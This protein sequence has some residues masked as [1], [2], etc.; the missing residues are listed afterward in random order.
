[1]PTL[2]YSDN[3][4][5]ET[6]FAVQDSGQKNRV[7]L[8]AAQDTS[9]LELSDN[10]NSTKG[11]VTVGGKKH[12]VILTAEMTG[13]GQGGGAVQIAVS[14]TAT[15]EGY[16]VPNPTAEEIT[17]IYNSLVA[18]K[19]VQIVDSNDV[20]YQV[21]QADSVDGAINIEALYF[22]EL[23]LLYTLENNTVTITG[24][25][26]GGGGGLP[27][28][29]GNAGKFLKT[30]GTDASWGKAL[31]NKATANNAIVI[32]DE[33]TAGTGTGNVAVGYK[34]T[35]SNSTSL[36]CVGAYSQ[37]SNSGT[38]IGYQAKATGIETI[39]IG[40]STTASG[41]YSANIGGTRNSVTGQSSIVVGY[42]AY[43][44]SAVGSIAI[45]AGNNGTGAQATGTCAIAIG[46]YTN[47]GLY[48][49]R[50]TSAGSVAIGKVAYANSN[51]AICL[52]S[53]GEASGA[54]SIAMGLYAK[55]SGSHSVLIGSKDDGYSST[56]TDANVFAFQNNNGVYVIIKSDGT[57][58][59][60]RLG[61]GYDA[62]KTQVLKNVQGVLTWVDE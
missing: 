54:G 55:V 43:T 9:T 1:M 32:G 59:P 47:Q 30:D 29:T 28:Q 13:G 48:C 11:Y 5:S 21:L 22:G 40:Y 6:A 39:S 57:I 60:N 20:Y 24:K 62:T 10:P 38:A 33:V 51:D 25:K 7:V 15:V 37:A 2:Q 12:R 46:G 4:N 17:A 56:L 41:F 34:A 52:G 35:L 14:G 58:D 53:N 3:P 18:G 16:T 44:S 42:R 23:A 26:I 50:A 61:T 49:A 27:D 31:E 8:T 36:V 19:N 45:G